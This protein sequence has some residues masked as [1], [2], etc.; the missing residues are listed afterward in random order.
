MISQSDR[1][2]SSF[3][4]RKPTALPAR[5][6]LGLCTHP[7]P[8]AST[9]LI[10]ADFQRKAG[11]E[12]D[13]AHHQIKVYGMWPRDLELANPTSTSLVRYVVNSN[14]SRS[15]TSTELIHSQ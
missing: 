11:P 10:I 13:W 8:F 6:R 15:G 1:P 3:V 14:M 2:L 5:A 7:R 4:D 9:K 12:R